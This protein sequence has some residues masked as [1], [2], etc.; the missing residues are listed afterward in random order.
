MITETVFGVLDGREI[1]LL[2]LRDGPVSVELIPLGAAVRAICVPDREGRTVDVC[3]GYDIRI[4]RR[5]KLRKVR[6]LPHRHQTSFRPSYK[7]NRRQG[8]TRRP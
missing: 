4:H 3:L 2:T 8:R 5:R 6:A 7:N 1:P